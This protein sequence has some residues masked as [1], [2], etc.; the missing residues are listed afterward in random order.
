[1]CVA[2]CVACVCLF[3]CGATMRQYAITIIKLND[4]GFKKRETYRFDRFKWKSKVIDSIDARAMP[5]MCVCEAK[6][7]LSG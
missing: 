7:V 1:M 6:C 5:D 2:V 3:A 4:N